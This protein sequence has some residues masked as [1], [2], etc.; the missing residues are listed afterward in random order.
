MIDWFGKLY[1]SKGKV[2]DV[3]AGIIDD[4]KVITIM[5]SIKQ[6]QVFLVDPVTGIPL[7]A[8]ISFAVTND[9]AETFLLLEAIK[10]AREKGSLWA[11]ERDQELLYTQALQGIGWTPPRW[12]PSC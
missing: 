10:E 7:R 8:D 11:N 4:V 5:N 1:C 3:R 6:D 12:P 2:L 9:E